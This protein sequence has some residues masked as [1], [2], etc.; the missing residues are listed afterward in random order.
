MMINIILMEYMYLI[1]LMIVR[2]EI[3]IIIL[4][5]ISCI[6]VIKRCEESKKIFSQSA[7]VLL[8]SSFLGVSAGG[9]LNSSIETLL[10]NHSLLTLLPL[11]SGVSGSLISIL[12][13]RLSSGLHYG[14]IEPLKRPAG[15]SIHNFLICYIL[16]VVMFPLIGFI[17]EDSTQI[18][19]LIGVGFANIILISLIAGLILLT[20]MIF[21]VYF[22]S[23][24]SYNR[25]LDPD[26]I[27]I[28]ISTS[29]TDMISS[30]TLIS[31]SLL[32]L[33]ALI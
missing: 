33:G 16:A 19:G 20:L 18:L 30:L 7:P 28:P 13:A 11:F 23:I 8:V 29:L 6:Y 5:I 25:D 4:I 22:I 1:L 15:E 32:I 31:V 12:S 26:N 14:L 27:V 3:I 9:I 2:K 10:T 17:A 24:T 21:V